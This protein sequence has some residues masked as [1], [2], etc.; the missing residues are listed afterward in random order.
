MKG[1]AM[2]I[3]AMEHEQPGATPAQFQQIAREEALK[4]WDL[5]QSGL[6]RELY[7]R[8][9]RR[10]AVLVLECASPDEAAA[11]LA[12][13]PM[14]RAGLITFELIPLVAYSGFARLFSTEDGE[15][16]AGD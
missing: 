12:G 11:V 10:T 8:A 4:V 5:T 9:D 7:F 2:K 1:Y 3:L 14:V 6:I 13:L 15:I 16:Q